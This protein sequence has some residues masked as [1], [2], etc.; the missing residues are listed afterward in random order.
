MERHGT[1]EVGNGVLNLPRRIL[2][3]L[4][5]VAVLT[6]T[7]G[8]AF[9]KPAKNESHYYLLT[10]MRPPGAAVGGS[11]TGTNLVVRLQPVEVANYLKTKDMAVRTGTNEVAFDLFHRWAEPLDDGVRR[12]LAE[13][14]RANSDIRAV[15]TDEPAPAPGPV[16]NVQVRVLACEGV[17]TNHGGEVMFKAVWQITRSG[18]EPTVVAHGVFQSTPAVWH[19]GDYAELAGQLSRAVDEFSHVLNVALTGYSGRSR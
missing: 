8:C 18:P 4:A 9:L 2:P 7:S 5:A 15:L 19:P 17:R 1:L 6:A 10:A 14:L 12:V 13:D 16:Y 11:R 3:V